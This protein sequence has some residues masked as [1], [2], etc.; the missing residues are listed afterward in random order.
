MRRFNSLRRPISPA[1]AELQDE[2]TREQRAPLSLRL[3]I[4]CPGGT[5]TLPIVAWFELRRIEA[6]HL[7]ALPFPWDAPASDLE[8]EDAGKS[9]V[10]FRIPAFMFLGWVTAYYA[11]SWPRRQCQSPSSIAPA[12]QN[13]PGNWRVSRIAPH[14]LRQTRLVDWSHVSACACCHIQ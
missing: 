1:D 8:G 9:A 7:F 11:D 3:I 4:C 5:G 6:G 12:S 13:P 14:G 10:E 2:P